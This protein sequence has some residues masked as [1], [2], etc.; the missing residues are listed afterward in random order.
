[1]ALQADERSLSEKTLVSVS[2]SDSV[3]HATFIENHR[4]SHE[5]LGAQVFTSDIKTQG[6]STIACQRP[7]DGCKLTTSRLFFA[8]AG[9]AM[10]LFLATTDATIVS[11]ILP[12]ITTQ[13]SASSS[14]YTWVTVTYMLTQTAFQPLYGKVSDLVGRMT[15]LYSSIIIFAVGNAL[16]AAAQ[17]IQWLII[18]RAVAGV[19]G[20]GIVSLVWIITA[21]IVEAESQAKWSQALSVTWACSAIAGPVLGGIFSE[22]SGILSW[23]WAFLLNLP[24]CARH[25]LGRSTDVTWGLLWKTFDFLGLFLFMA[26]SSCIVIG[27][28][29]SAS[30]GWA[31]PSTI[32]LIVVGLVILVCGG[33]YEVRTRR[34]ALFPSA[35]F[36]DLTIVSTLVVVF[37][38]NFAF[39]AG[40]FYLALF[41]QAVDGLSPLQAG[42]KMLPY[43]LGSSLASMPA[44]WFIGYWQKRRQDLIAQKLVIS[45]GLAIATIGFGLMIQLTEHTGVVTRAVYVMTAGIGIGFLFHAPYQVFIR[46]LRRTDTA[47][48]TSAFFLV[49]FTGATVGLTLAGAIFDS[50]LAETLPP[51]LHASTILRLVR[52]LQLTSLK[53]QVVHSLSLSIQ[54]IWVVCC[55]CLG[56]ALLVCAPLPSCLNSHCSGQLSLCLRNPPSVASEESR[57]GPQGGTADTDKTDLDLERSEMVV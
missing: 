13:L 4:A 20:G 15:V 21:E 32:C 34:D 9:A 6:E 44:A 28:N 47:S 27:L 51:G 16:C 22:D 23:R 42:I 41:F 56:V 55:P 19:G 52:S 40:T 8:H 46:A 35:V 17:N 53:S 30:A 11:T 39:N 57:Q 50:R 18:A 45:A 29:I 33:M 26:A 54:A 1:M 24:I 10:A 38:H 12:T 37:L 3:K 5:S 2:D 31:S 36:T 7:E 49:R 25:N 14:Q 43:S 48:G